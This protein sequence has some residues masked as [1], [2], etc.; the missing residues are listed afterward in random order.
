MFARGEYWQLAYHEVD[1]RGRVGL[2]HDLSDEDGPIW[3]AIERLKRIA[4]DRF[5][6]NTA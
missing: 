6:R 3:L 4:P 2:R 5:R 1:L